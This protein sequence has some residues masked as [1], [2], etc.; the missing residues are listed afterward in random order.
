LTTCLQ[1]FNII[2]EIFLTAHRIAIISSLKTF[3]QEVNVK[4]V[5]GCIFISCLSIYIPKLFTHSI[6][7]VNATGA[8]SNSTPAKVIY[9]LTKTAFGKSSTG[10]LI[11]PVLT[12]TRIVLVSIVLLVLNIVCVIQFKAYLK[13]KLR[14]KSLNRKT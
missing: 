11:T 2:L 10:V 6:T 3:R 5:S 13:N 1:M 7:N 14:I 12:T 4:L 8:E 9:K